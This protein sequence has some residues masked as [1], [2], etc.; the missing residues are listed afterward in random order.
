[1]SGRSS[2]CVS[3]MSPIVAM[4][5][6]D[7]L[8]PSLADGMFDAQM[9]EYPGNDEVHQVL[10]CGRTMVESG[11]GRHDHCA[12]PRD[13]KHVLEMHRAVRRLARN[14]HKWTAFLERDVGSAFHERTRLA[15][16]DGAP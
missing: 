2:P 9:V 12:R 14:Q 7:R 11:A 8:I 15:L 6:S 16:A 4:P 10:H 13:P 3:E 1:M 5:A